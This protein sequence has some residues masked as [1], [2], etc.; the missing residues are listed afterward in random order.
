MFRD[1]RAVADGSVL[2]CDV[3]IIGS[4]AAGATAAI[5]LSN[6]GLRVLVAEAGGIK[7]D[8]ELSSAYDLDCSSLPVSPTSRQRL[9]GGTTNSWWG[10][11]ALLDPGDFTARPSI[12]AGGWPITRADLEPYYRRACAL[13]GIPD[14]TRFDPSTAGSVRGRLFGG[15]ALATKSFFWSRRPANFGSLLRRR[16]DGGRAVTT[17]LHANV[18]QVLLGAGDVVEGLA[19]ATGN[20]RAFVIRPRTTV[21][22]CGGIENARLLLNSR[23][24]HPAGVGNGY[25]QVG[26]YYMDHPRGSCG[27]IDVDPRASMPSPSYWSGKRFGQLRVRLGVGLSPEGQTELRALNSYVNL[28]PVYGGASGGAVEALRTA[29]R[30]GLSGAADPEALRAVVSGLPDVARYIGFKRWGLGR[31]SH[32]IVENY[33]EQEPSATNRVTRSDRRDEFGFPTARID[34]SL[35]D[36][37]RVSLVALHRALDDDLRRRGIGRLRS[38]IMNGDAT[39]WPVTTD[40]AHHMGTTRMGTDPRSSVVDPNGLVHGVKNLYLAGSSVFP[41]GGSAN[42]TLTI[43]AL[44][45]RLADE[46]R[47]VRAC[48]RAVALRGA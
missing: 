42:P 33:M 25:D 28:N 13:L 4:G 41:T 10:K 24:Q 17:L 19:V 29:Y 37:D 30:R 39:E 35:S 12:S 31:V 34:W 15:G 43:V 48:E 22:A 8:A 11:V 14:L 2:E 45:I 3:C 47:S 23:A 7:P 32:L 46:I 9:Y 40:A 36:L 20:G 6:R 1:A 18:T 26:R 16:V 5:E 44:A 21:V 38:P 27:I